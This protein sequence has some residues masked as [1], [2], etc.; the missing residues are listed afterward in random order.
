M[1]LIEAQLDLGEVLA[2]SGDVTRAREAYTQARHL[3][4]EKGGVVLLATV[5]RRLESLENCVG[6]GLQ[7][8]T[9]TNSPYQSQ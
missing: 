1:L 6:A 4:E 7:P 9:D 8:G 2:A 5:F 3:A